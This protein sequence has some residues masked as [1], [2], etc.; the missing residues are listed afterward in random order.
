MTFL[1]DEDKKKLLGSLYC[2]VYVQYRL[3]LMSEGETACVNGLLFLWFL[4]FLGS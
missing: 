1:S 3:W 4:F 2:I